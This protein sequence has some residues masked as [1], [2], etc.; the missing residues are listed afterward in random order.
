M[1]AVKKTLFQPDMYVVLH[2]VDGEEDVYTAHEVLPEFDEDVLAAQ[3]RLVSI[4]EVKLTRQYVPTKEVE[5]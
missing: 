5:K 1:P 4:G 2:Q 3:Y